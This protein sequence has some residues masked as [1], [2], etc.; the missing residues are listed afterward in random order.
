MN[1]A[2]VLP[3]GAAALC[4]AIHRQKSGSAPRGRDVLPH[5]DGGT[6]T[7]WIRGTARGADTRRSAAPPG[8][9]IE[10]PDLFPPRG[11]PN[12]RKSKHW[13]AV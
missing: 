13:P 12:F 6:G 5:T 2:H 9:G 3:S 7:P 1:R 11:I 4:R 10:S 8:P